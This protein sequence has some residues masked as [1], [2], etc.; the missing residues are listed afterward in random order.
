MDLTKISLSINEF[1]NY[2]QQELPVFDT[3][4]AEEVKYGFIKGSILIPD[5]D[6]LEDWINSIIGQEQEFL[7]LEDYNEI[8]NKLKKFPSTTYQNIKGFLRVGLDGWMKAEQPMDILISIDKEELTLD[9]KHDND[10][11]LLDVRSEEEYKKGHLKNAI[12][13]PIDKL[14]EHLS[15]LS[16]EDKLY[17]YSQEGKESIIAVSL[18]RKHG[19][20]YSRNIELGFS[21]LQDTDIPIER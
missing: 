4:S 10:M 18:L 1:L 15:Y 5:A 9:Y 20:Y 12:N 19:Y 6:N 7:L 14:K 16:T 2:Y 8:E 11:K 13:V 21:D 3:R 17:V